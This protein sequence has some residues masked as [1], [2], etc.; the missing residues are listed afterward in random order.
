MQNPKY[1]I[2]TVSVPST[3]EGLIP[4]LE[5][6]ALESFSC[7]G[8]E[9]FALDEANVDQILG[10]RAYSGFDIPDEVFSEVEDET[11][12]RFGQ[13]FKFYFYEEDA[14]NHATTFRTQA[15]KD[16]PTLGF[17]LNEEEWKDWNAEWKKH[18]RTLEISPRLKVIPEWEKEASWKKNQ[19]AV[20]IIPGMGFGTGNHETTCL[21][22]KFL[23]ELKLPSNCPCLD[24]GC[25]SGILGIAAIKLHRSLV[26]FCDIDRKALDNC[27]ENIKLNFDEEMLDG[28]RLVARD[29]FEATSE[30]YQLTLANILEPVLIEEQELLIKSLAPQGYLI[31][32]GLLLDQLDGIIA[33]YTTN[34]QLNFVKKETKGHWGAL[35]F[36]K[37]P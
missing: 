9:E 21:C 26:D 36:Q 8:I 15:Q 27:Y 22:L 6:M 32:S 11:K 28:Q 18:Y 13:H 24:F 10:L 2:V 19:N 3:H 33:R 34:T 25:G 20:Y 16:F 14:Q 17:N 7:G 31:V 35:L 30:F 23:D 4:K 1:Y 29:R 12:K 5:K 37:N